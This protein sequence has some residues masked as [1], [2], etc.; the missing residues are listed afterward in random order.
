[1]FKQVIPA[2]LSFSDQRRASTREISRISRGGRFALGGV[3]ARTGVRR[4][5]ALVRFPFS[6]FGGRCY[7]AKLSLIRQPRKR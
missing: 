2:T 3:S 6:G 5:I 1:M 7:G 4:S